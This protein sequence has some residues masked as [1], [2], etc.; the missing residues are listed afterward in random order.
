[1]SL[2]HVVKLKLK[3]FIRPLYAFTMPPSYH[4]SNMYCLHYACIS[5]FRCSLCAAKLEGHYLP[6]NIRALPG[7]QGFQDIMQAMH[8]QGIDLFMVHYLQIQN[9]YGSIR[10]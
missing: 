10:R 5:E 9:Q 1:M 8:Y 2:Y 3:H 6:E 7:I 4:H